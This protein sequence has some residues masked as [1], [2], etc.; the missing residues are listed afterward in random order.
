SEATVNGQMRYLDLAPRTIGDRT[1]VPMR[2][3]GDALGGSVTWNGDTNMVAIVTTATSNTSSSYTPPP[4][5]TSPPTSA[6]IS[7]TTDEIVPVSL[8]EQL[9]STSSHVGDTFTATVTGN[10]YGDMPASTKIEGHVSSVSEM[11][12]TQPGFIDLAFDKIDFP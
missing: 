10:G 6:N 4:D 11:T 8:D 12:D 1:M 7:L 2:F 5:E 3:L 9:D